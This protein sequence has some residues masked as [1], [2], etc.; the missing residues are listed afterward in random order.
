MK[1]QA[2]PGPQTSGWLPV[3]ILLA[4]TLAPS[5]ASAQGWVDQRV[6]GPLVCNADFPLTDVEP[7]L[8]EVAQIQQEL[9]RLLEIPPTNE[10]IQLLLFRDRAAY[11]RYLAQHLPNVPYRQALYVRSAGQGTVLAFRSEDLPIDVRHECTHA[12][13]HSVLPMVPLWLDEGLAEYF[14]VPETDRRLKNPHH[15]TVIWW[16]RF[17]RVP[18][19]QRLETRQTLDEMGRTEYRDAWAYAHFLLNG[20]PSARAELVSY[21][22]DIRNG[23]PPGQLSERLAKLTPD[24]PGE[25]VEHFK[26]LK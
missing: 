16:M 9:I 17:G 26:T 8:A 11:R 22:A 24:L 23:T 10:R 2:E 14:E 15:S 21:L 20:P 5:V 6:Y 3:V 19:M 1:R 25:L 4:L 18:S 12:L 13:L 7:L